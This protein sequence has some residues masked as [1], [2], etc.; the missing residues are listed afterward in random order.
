MKIW[1][2]TFKKSKL[3]LSKA[4]SF[5]EGTSLFNMMVTSAN[6]FDLPC[7]VILPKHERYIEDF[8]IVKFLKSDFIEEMPYDYVEVEIF[9]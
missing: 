7:P 8:G 3:K 9:E 5:E 4:F 2:K 6:D 1:F